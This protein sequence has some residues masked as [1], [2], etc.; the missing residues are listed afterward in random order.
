[1]ADDS[2]RRPRGSASG[3]A[4]P[5][6][7]IVLPVK[8][9]EFRDFLS[10]LL[11]KPQTIARAFPGVFEVT[12]EDIQSFY[13]LVKQRIDQQNDATILQFNVRVVFDDNSSV[14][15]NSFE[16]FVHYNEVRPIAS[17][18]AHLSWALLI[19]FRDKDV[20]EKQ[21]ID[22]SI[23]CYER[24]FLPIFDEQFFPLGAHSYSAGY[25]DVRIRHTARTWGADIEALLS[26]HIKTLL[27]VR[28]RW[29]EFL[30]K[31]HEGIGLLTGPVFLL[32]ALCGGI[33]ATT[34][35]AATQLAGLPP[36]GTTADA[37]IAYLLKAVATGSWPRF[38]IYFA[39]Y[40][41]VSLA[42]SVT[43]MIW[44]TSANIRAEPSFLPLSK[45]SEKLKAKLQRSYRR[46]WISAITGFI[47]AVVASLAGC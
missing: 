14:L 8:P 13:H 6:Y 32:A 42:L 25:I 28:S 12:S 35:F 5:E 39:I 21:E 27:K 45:Q 7:A 9:E 40:L 20:P 38:S 47:T 11:G 22:V 37:Q 33:V 16:D 2:E 3:S 15:L 34:R 46:Q 43:F 19:R 31:Y 26:N 10:G 29:R 23:V 36:K 24:P 1:M 18:A 17:V 4:S 44:I 41:T 30:A